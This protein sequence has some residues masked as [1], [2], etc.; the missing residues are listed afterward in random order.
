MKKIVISGSSKLSEQTA[1]WRGYFEGRGYE[2]LD[3]P[4]PVPEGDYAV[5]M[6]KIYRRFYRHLDNTNAFFLMN[7]DQNDIEGYI[8]S[9]AMSEL[10][11]VVMN[12]LNHDKHVEVFILQEPSDQQ[13]HF[14]EVKFWL[15]QGW[16]KVY[17]KPTER[18]NKTSAKAILSPVKTDTATKSLPATTSSNTPVPLANTIKNPVLSTN[19]PPTLSPSSNPIKKLFSSNDNNI[20]KTIDITACRKKCLRPLTIEKR[21]YLKILCADFPIWLLKYIAVPE[22]QRLSKVA[23]TSVDYGSIYQFPDFNSVFDHSIGVA[24]IVWKFTHD[25]KQTIAALYHDIASPAFKHAIDYMNDDAE[26][27]ESTE[28]RTSEIIRNSKNIMRLLHKDNI[29]ASEVTD[30]HLY[31]I[32]DNSVPRLAA[33]RLEYTLSNGLFLYETW[34]LAQVRYFYDN[35]TILKNEDG[36]AEL[37]FSDQDIC[38]EFIELALPL[39]ANY[40]S[41]EARASLQFIADII[42]S[43]IVKAYLTYDDL[44]LMSEREI[45]DWILGCGDR[46]ISDAFR[47]YQ[48]ATTVFSS[49]TI[50]KDRYCTDVKAKIRYIDPL[51]KDLD[52][53][54]EVHR[55]S[56]LSN[57]IARKLK[58]YLDDKPSKYTGFDF[59]FI[60][61]SE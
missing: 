4:K 37:G 7:E 23:M 56:E 61:Y 16:I 40:H 42:K 34:D 10:S 21:E 13:T 3:W 50:K 45:I 29:L 38:E 20:N 44:Y 43:M 24:L 48:R 52:D 60:P 11:Y 2:I 59:E 12:N 35:I 14:T 27:Q 32:A 41:N 53:I 49:N 5:E 26:T 28:D 19:L 17:E 18:K 1:Y 55:I 8:G 30:Y 54:E 9:S 6:T 58:K 15:D 46:T 51:V 33:D 31:P 25:Q 39:F 57:S 22:F 36:I 47:Q